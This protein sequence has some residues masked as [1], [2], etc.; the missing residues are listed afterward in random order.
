MTNLII[1]SHSIFFS[2]IMSVVVSF[3]VEVYYYRREH[4]SSGG[5]DAVKDLELVDGIHQA[6]KLNYDATTNSGRDES[7]SLTSSSS[8][9]ESL[10]DFMKI[11]SLSDF[12][13]VTC[14]RPS[15]SVVIENVI[16]ADNPGVYLC[17]PRSLLNAV[18]D[19]VNEKR[20]DCAIYEEDSEM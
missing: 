1:R 6:K 11:S 4:I 9:S 12:L 15:I 16:K 19:A 18:K 3:L 13:N 20:K 2:L 5:Y 14:G 17:G 7:S 10:A 8:S